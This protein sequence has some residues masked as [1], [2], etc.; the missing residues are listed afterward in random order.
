[1]NIKFFVKIGESASE[2]LLL[3]TVAYGEYAMKEL[4]VFEWHRWLIERR[5]DVQDDP[6]S[7][8]QEMQRTDANVDRVRTLMHSDRRLCVRLIA[9]LNMDRET[10]CQIMEDSGMR[11]I[12]TKMVPQILTNNQ[13][14]L[15]FYTMQSCLI[16]SLLVMKLGVFSTAWK[17]NAKACSGK[18]RIHLGR[19]KAHMSRLQ[20]KTMPM[21]FFSH[22]VIVHSEFITQE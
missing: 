19:K 14:R 10:V 17:Q 11:K 13:K 2:T 16:E 6:R 7:G 5:N 15:I 8:Q 12:S 20:L 4:S 1:M 3:L 18:H 9:E 21:C 22:R